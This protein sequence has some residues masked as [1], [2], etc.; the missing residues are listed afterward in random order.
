MDYVIVSQKGFGTGNIKPLNMLY[1]HLKALT[2]NNL[3]CSKC[4]HLWRNKSAPYPEE[5]YI[6]NIS[7][8]RHAIVCRRPGG[9]N[10]PEFCLRSRHM[11]SHLRPKNP[12]GL[13]TARRWRVQ[14]TRAL[15]AS[16]TP[17]ISKRS[18]VEATCSTEEMSKQKKNLI[19]EWNLIDGN[20]LVMGGRV[21]LSAR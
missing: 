21:A 15:S 11:S 13:N 17:R 5:V 10:G 18:E 14:W 9:S 16:C 8:R 20:G 2:D 4:S 3:P 7:S 6:R 19:A 12:Q 1:S